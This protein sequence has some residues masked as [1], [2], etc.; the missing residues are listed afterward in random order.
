M[1]RASFMNLPL[2]TQQAFSNVCVIEYHGQSMRPLSAAL[3][4]RLHG[5]A[6]NTSSYIARQGTEALATLLFRRDRHKVQVINQGLQLPCAEIARFVDFVFRTF[7]T[8]SVVSFEAIKVNLQSFR[9][10][11]LQTMRSKNHVHIFRSRRAR[12]HHA[13][14]IFSTYL[15]RG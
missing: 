7:P 13:G 12:L 4:D 3:Q 10:P 14:L 11:Y 1:Y 6:Q 9:L 2:R 5:D 15:Q 8:A